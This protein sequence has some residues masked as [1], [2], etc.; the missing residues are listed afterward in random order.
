MSI[1]LKVEFPGRRWRH[2]P[3]G[4]NQGA[5]PLPQASHR[6][7]S[8]CWRY[9]GH[10]VDTSRGIVNN[11]K[12]D[13]K[14]SSSENVTDRTVSW[15]NLTEGYWRGLSTPVHPLVTHAV[16]LEV[17]IR[18]CIC[19][20]VG[21]WHVAF[22]LG[23]KKLWSRRYGNTCFFLKLE[24]WSLYMWDHLALFTT[25]S[26]QIPADLSLF[27]VDS[28]ISFYLFSPSYRVKFRPNQTNSR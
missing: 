2:S 13:K 7:P 10:G 19:N 27:P 9:Q 28:F 8:G 17:I 11:R 14:K 23:C 16:T 20:F 24:D 22:F 15:G 4:T 3:G 5:A 26:S 1:L 25:R 21:I 18:I 12:K 6:D